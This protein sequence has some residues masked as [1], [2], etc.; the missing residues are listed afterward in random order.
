MVD[1]DVEQHFSNAE[2]MLPDIVFNPIGWGPTDLLSLDT[3]FPYQ[4]YSKSELIGKIADFTGSFVN[5]RQRNKYNSLYSSGTKYTYTHEDDES[6]FQT[7]DTKTQK[8][9]LPRQRMTRPN[10]QTQARLRL[11]RE[12]RRMNAFG[13]PMTQQTGA[14]NPH[15]QRQQLRKVQGGNVMGGGRGGGSQG[16]MMGRGGPGQMG[17]AGRGAMREAS[18]QIKDS[19]VLKEEMDF[20]RLNKLHMEAPSDSQ[21][22]I[23]CGEMEYYD[24]KY[25]RVA[26]QKSVALQRINRLCHS[27]T[28]SCDPVIFELMTR[29]EGDVYLTDSIMAALMCCTRSVYSWDIVV[30]RFKKRLIFDKRDKS[31]FDF[32]TV[33]ET[34][35]NPP[36]EEANHI[37]SSRN[38]SLEATFINKNFSQQ[39]LKTGEE[40]FS[41]DRPYPFADEEEN[42]ELA[43]IGYRYRRYTLPNGT[44][45]VVRCEQ[46]A[47]MMAPNQETQ[48]INIKALNEWDSRACNGVDWRTK[49]DSQRGAVL[50]AELKNNAYKLAKWTCCALLAG[51]DQIKFGYVSRVNP[52]D[53][54]RHEILGTQ[55]FKPIELAN[56][57]NLDMAKAWGIFRCIIDICM[58]LPEGKYL[59]MKDPNKSA[60]RLYD[61]PKDTFET[62]DEGEGDD[63]T[64]EKDEAQ[65]NQT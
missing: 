41:F 8:T 1:Y 24:K 42:C 2:L 36:N 25:D 16:G 49:L 30:N 59:I 6:T 65:E 19:F 21:D 47:A 64:P 9:F 39:V 13:L 43:S 54:N 62:E 45:I 35:S 26:V 23:C 63:E 15:Q 48:F 44:R 61:I 55:Q 29:Q 12:R 56:Q 34:A 57:I 28:T 10:M 27:V 14:R 22:L 7:V 11:D 33:N 18:V 46:D 58:K 32:L 38:L 3:E 4:P 20:V 60:L 51:S 50:A 37:N 31:D 5:E 40:K 53:S 17:G 52:M